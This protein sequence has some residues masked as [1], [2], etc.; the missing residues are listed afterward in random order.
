MFAKRNVI[1]PK[2]VALGHLSFGW[3]TPERE[4]FLSL[5][6]NYLGSNRIAG[7]Y[8]EF[9]VWRGDTLCTAYH[10]AQDL[11]GS[12]PAFK[13]M[14]FYAFDSFE[15]FPELRGDD[16]HPQ[17]RQGGRACSEEEF[18]RIVSARNVP[19]ER[20]TVTRGWFKDTLGKC[21]LPERSLAAAYVDCDL[22]DSTREVLECIS[23]RM[24]AGAVLVFDDWFCFGGD[25]HKGEQKACR[26]FL[27]KHPEVCLVQF[28]NFGW[29]GTSFLFHRTA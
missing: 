26:E 3:T 27:A 6:L 21:T 15:G 23:P 2:R 7:D 14:R 18:L 16:I 22:Y 13:E 24:A 17:F 19:A 28:Q 8:A 29:H 5:V 4:L 20:L 11:A 12:F 9:G 10:L 1:V 25:P